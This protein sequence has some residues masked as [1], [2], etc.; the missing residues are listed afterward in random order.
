MV[1]NLFKY[2]TKLIDGKQYV[3][4]CESSQIY[5]GKGVK[6]Q[7]PEDEDFQV[8]ILRIEGKLYC[9]DNICPH[10]HMDKIYDGII[11]NHTV[12]CPAHGWTYNVKT[13]ENMNKHQGLKSL[14]VYDVFEKDGNVFIE[15]PDFEVPKWRRF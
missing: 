2:E 9:M 1:I 14:N 15:K 7:F 10:R 5:D 12:M 8:A 3:K 11:K 13:G 6:I 4:A